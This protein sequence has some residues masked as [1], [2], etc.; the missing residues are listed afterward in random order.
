[1]CFP[2]HV[3][4]EVSHSE[5]FLMLCNGNA[6]Q[7]PCSMTPEGASRLDK[8]KKHSLGG[9]KNGGP[10]KS[11]H[12]PPPPPPQH[13][14][15]RMVDLELRHKLQI[16]QRGWTRTSSA[17]S[18]EHNGFHKTPLGLGQQ[19]AA[20]R[21]ACFFDTGLSPATCG[22]LLSWSMLST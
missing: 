8:Q 14:R 22:G 18:K 17:S 21:T 6:P 19:A 9:L 4:G 3:C 13:Q 11:P 10:T 15:L 1:M 12:P 20:P 16:C 2:V 7:W 5:S